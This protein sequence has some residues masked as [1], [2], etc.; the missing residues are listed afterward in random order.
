MAVVD[1]EIAGPVDPLVDLAQAAWLNAKLY[2]DDDSG[3]EGL[4][5]YSERVAQLKAIV[6]A[7]GLSAKERR[8]FIDLM[9]V[10]NV[11][12]TAFQADEAKVTEESTD[13][14]ALW[15]LAWRARSAVWLMKERTNLQNAIR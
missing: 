13:P 9:I 5:P 2:G 7:Y 1:W 15:G 10:V 14:E 8:E 12:D 11:H 3:L 6:D 4:A